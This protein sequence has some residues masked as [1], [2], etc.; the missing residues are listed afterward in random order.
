MKKLFFLLIIAFI[1]TTALAQSPLKLVYFQNYAPF[2]WKV[3]TQMHGILI[4]VLNEAIEVRMGI[5][6]SHGGYPWKRAQL[7]VRWNE[8]DAFATVP[9]PERRAYTEISTEPVVLATITMFIRKGNPEIE[10]L[11]KVR[12]VSD[13]KPF[14]LG[15][16]IGSGWAKKNLV[17]LNVSWSPKLDHVLAKLNEGR[18][19]VF[20]DTSQVVRYNIKKLGYQDRIIELPNIIDSAPFRL[21]IGKKSSYVNILSKFDEIIKE[22]KKDGKLQEIYDNYK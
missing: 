9:T 15:H 7:M 20:V 10:E 6:V 14:K 12:T 4:D 1:P 13:L 22:M 5:P 2:S 16:Y 3:N 11:K 17:D 21:C 8:A 18:I 19:D